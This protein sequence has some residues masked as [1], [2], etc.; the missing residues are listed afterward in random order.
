MNFIDRNKEL[1]RLEAALKGCKGKLLV[2][3]GRR[4]L[5]KS[6]LIKRI[7]KEGDVYYE[8]TKSESST[9]RLGLA[10][11]VA[12]LYNDFDKPTYSTWDSLLSA[13]NNQCKE[14]ATLMLD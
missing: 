3:Y 9:Q 5:G 13:F 1:G 6:R 7:L 2:V 11:S 14:G 10:A 12:L 4:R 8:A